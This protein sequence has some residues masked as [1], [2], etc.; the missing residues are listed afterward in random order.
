[1]IPPL[2]CVLCL[3]DPQMT[4]MLGPLASAT[5]IVVPVLL[6]KNI[7]AA[8][9]GLRGGRV[10]PD[11]PG[12]ERRPAEPARGP[13]TAGDDALDEAEPPGGVHP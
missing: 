2:G 5:V 3:V 13:E 9:R 6:R 1:M 4:T 12:A 11:E 8:I 7:T 10:G